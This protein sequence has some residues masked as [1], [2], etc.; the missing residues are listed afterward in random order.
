[1]QAGVP[2]PPSGMP[3]GWTAALD[4]ASGR[5]YYVNAATGASQWDPPP[6]MGSI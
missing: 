3:A 6:G 1:M 2:P 5:T 4:P